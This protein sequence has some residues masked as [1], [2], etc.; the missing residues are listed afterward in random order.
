M[1]QHVAAHKL[2]GEVQSSVA[3]GFC[4][5]KQ[6][7]SSML[8]RG[9]QKKTTV[10][11]S[12]CI[13]F[14]KFQVGRV[15]NRI[16]G[17]NSPSSNIPVKCPDCTAVPHQP[18]LHNI[19]DHYRI[20]HPNTPRQEQLTRIQTLLMLRVDGL[21]LPTN[22][23]HGS[24]SFNYERVGENTLMSQAANILSSRCFDDLPDLKKQILKILSEFS[25]VLSKEKTRKRK[26]DE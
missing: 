19:F 23:N 2:R 25:L 22:T 8:V 11:H 24:P 16:I 15:E 12:S 3:C 13:Q 4:G 14:H 10:P 1:R 5:K 17:G 6:G 7:C 26:S 18:W 9:S 21:L 20:H